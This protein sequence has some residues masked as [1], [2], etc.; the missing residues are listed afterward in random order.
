M[1]PQTTIFLRV[2][3]F[4]SG[5][6]GSFCSG[7]CFPDRASRSP[8]SNCLR[9]EMGQKNHCSGRHVWYLDFR[10]DNAVH[11]QTSRQVRTQVDDVERSHFSGIGTNIPIGI[12]NSLAV[13]LCLHHCTLHSGT[14]P[15]EPH[16]QNYSSEFFQ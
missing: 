5:S 7:Q 14:Q 3:G 6:C 12:P 16:T 1:A 11:R 13:L 9:H 10:Y 15:A 8:R 2:V 4:R